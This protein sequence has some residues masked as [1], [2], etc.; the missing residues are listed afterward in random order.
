MSSI[1]RDR[2]IAQIGG[3]DVQN[4]LAP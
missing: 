2:T 1:Y 4:D 3:S